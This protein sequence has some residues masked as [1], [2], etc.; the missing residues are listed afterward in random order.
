MHSL[1][2]ANK[3]MKAS[4]HPSIVTAQAALELVRG[5]AWLL[6]CSRKVSSN[7]PT[8]YWFLVIVG[9]KGV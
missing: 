9:N 1:L 2:R 3:L 7:L 4:E 8:T 5:E 6:A